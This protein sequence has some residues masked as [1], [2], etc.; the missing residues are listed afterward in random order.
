MSQLNDNTEISSLIPGVVNTP[1]PI[2]DTNERPEN[3]ATFY[4]PDVD[5]PFTPF[6]VLERKEQEKAMQPNALEWIATSMKHDWISSWMFSDTQEPQG[7]PDPNFT[8]DEETFLKVTEGLPIEHYDKFEDA[9]SLQHAYGIRQQ[10]LKRLEVESKLNSIGYGALPARMLM[11]LLDPVVLGTMLGTAGLAGVHLGI[12]T[13]IGGRLTHMAALGYLTGVEAAALTGL[14]ADKDILFDDDDV[15]FAAL[16]GTALGGGVGAFTAKAGA[17]RLV[18]NRINKSGGSLALTKAGQ[19]AVNVTKN[20][21]S[22]SPAVDKVLLKQDTEK[23]FAELNSSLKGETV[24]ELRSIAKERNIKGRSRMLKKD[25]VN[26][27]K[28]DMGQERDEIITKADKKARITYNRAA[29]SKEK[30]KADE[31]PTGF[32]NVPYQGL[33]LLKLGKRAVRTR[34]GPAAV[35]KNNENGAARFLGRI[36]FADATADV[37]KVAG[38][39]TLVE[40]VDTVEEIVRR[41][42]AQSLAILRNEEN[43]L[44]SKHFKE[45]KRSWANKLVGSDESK[46]F[47]EVTSLIRTGNIDAASSGVVKEIALLHRDY[48]RKMLKYA[49]EKGIKGLEDVPDNQMYVPRI[50]SLRKIEELRASLK[51]GELDRLIASTLKIDGLDPADA[52]RIGKAFMSKIH[53]RL[54]NHNLTNLSV[55]GD[56]VVSDM[57]KALKDLL[58]DDELADKLTD[59]IEEN[60][61]KKKPDSGKISRAKRRVPLDENL[62]VE[63]THKDGTTAKYTLQDLLENDAR[64]LQMRYDRQV[65]GAAQMNRVIED[66]SQ[67]AGKELKTFSDVKRLVLDGTPS[68]AK[69][70]NK[71]KDILEF[72][73]KIILGKPLTQPGALKELATAARDFNYWRIGGTFGLASIPETVYPLIG[74]TFKA[75]TQQMP[76]FRK[77]TTDASKGTLSK[78]TLRD[79]HYLV[80]AG[81]D[82]LTMQFTGRVDDLGLLANTRISKGSLFREKTNRAIS[83]VSGLNWLTRNQQEMMARVTLQNIVNDALGTT[84]KSVSKTRY[85]Q[86][87][88]SDDMFAR[89]EKLLKDPANGIVI[90]DVKGIGKI[91]DPGS[92]NKAFDVAADQEAVSALVS[93]V[94]K[95]TES[96]IQR[97]YMGDLPIWMSTEMGKLMGQFRTYVL[98]A[99]NRQLMPGFQRL[100]N[101]DFSVVRD[102]SALMLFGALTYTLQSYLRTLGDSEKRE[103]YLQ[104]FEIAKGAFARAGVSSLIPGAV[105][106]VGYFFGE[107]PF[108]KVRTSGLASGFI[109]GSPTVQ[110]IDLLTRTLKNSNM[111]LFREDYDFS[112]KTLK[113]IKR[114]APFANVPII[115]QSLEAGIRYAPLPDESRNSDNEL[116][117]LL[118][119]LE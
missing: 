81:T 95:F 14:Q 86:L 61:K 24:K 13:G 110:G 91:V 85:L 70:T 55:L 114:L 39:K 22:F 5:R 101:N 109:T 48:Y 46:I 111:A 25:L 119:E 37:Q 45:N 19:K 106:T 99:W 65:R 107:Q 78:D 89:I 9:V 97:T 54:A 87:G 72:T 12:G 94:Q 28:K 56:D 73:E 47:E 51:S 31:G 90:N 105:D 117:N 1:D 17:N 16:L 102:W 52:L 113:D 93:G 34:Y 88:I 29:R 7:V 116:R 115:S 27:I 21:D 60:F 44:L 76:M 35:L 92:L 33:G 26:A 77:L 57:R 20:F 41:E 103:E 4:K 49:R 10:L 11:T 40:S 69:T 84:K 112:K 18:T 64:T 38:K 8:F 71:M 23:W 68:D 3:V 96:T 66:F 63:L 100:A 75:F 32:D 79:F 15:E 53:N 74:G 2:V 62:E 59:V 50:Y 118:R 36:V 80:G 98:T 6:E 43:M 104:P 42:G 67:K 58:E 82:R 108:S 83:D 30:I